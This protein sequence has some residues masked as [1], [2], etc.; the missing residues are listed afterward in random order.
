M[1]EGCAAVADIIRAVSRLSGKRN[2]DVA[3]LV[4]MNPQAFNNRLSRDSFSAYE[5][6]R[7]VG[8]MG[9]RLVVEHGARVFAVDP[10]GGGGVRAAEAPELASV[11]D[12]PGEPGGADEMADLFVRMLGL[13]AR[14]EATKAALA[15]RLG[16]PRA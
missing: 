12:G 6:A 14:D 2:R 1:R 8:L 16:D 7:I 4:G 15:E 10:D 9:G 11:V 5:L 13:L 3:D